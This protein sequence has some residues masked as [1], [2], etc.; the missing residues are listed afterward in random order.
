MRGRR[1]ERDV[2]PIIVTP[3]IHQDKMLGTITAVRRKG[4]KDFTQHDVDLMVAITNQA[5]AAVRTAHLLEQTQ[6][7]LQETQTLYR[8]SR[9][10]FTYKDLP[11]LLR[12]V[13]NGIAEALPASRVMLLNVDREAETVV[14]M[15]VGGDHDEEIPVTFEELW[16]GLTGWVLRHEQ[17]AF[18]AKGKRDARERDYVQEGREHFEFGS[19]IVVPLRY[20]DN[21]FGTITAMNM[22]DEPDFTQRDVDLMTAMANQAAAAIENARL[23][24][25]TRRVLQETR[26]ISSVSQALLQAKRPRHAVRKAT[27][28]VADALKADRVYILTMDLEQR[29]I[30][31]QTKGGPEVRDFW[32]LTFDEAMQGLI[33]WVVREREPVLS[34][35][36][37]LDPR[38]SPA[39][40]H[41]RRD[42]DAGC[43]MI[44]PLEYS[45][46]I[47]GIIAA[48]N[49]S[50]ERD[51]TPHDLKQL[52]LMAHQI[53]AAVENARL[54]EQTQQALA[55]TEALYQV[56][57]SVISLESLR[58]KL[59]I[60]TD[61]VASGLKAN[62]VL[63]ITLDLECNQVV[64]HVTG[65]EGQRFQ[66]VPFE[67]LMAGLTGWVVRERKPA[68]SPKGEPD[69]REGRA[70]QQ[71]RMASQA[72]SILVVPL[73]YEE[74][75]LG[76]LTAI[77]RLDQPD[78]TSDDA[79]LMMTMANQA[80]IAIKN[81]QLVEG[82]EAQV[83]ARTA[84]IRAEQE[85]TEAILQ[86]AGDA[87]AMVDTRLRIRYVNQAFLDLTNYRSEE[88]LDQRATVLLEHTLG[89][90]R[91]LWPSIR[92]DLVLRKIWHGETT[93]S[94]AD[95]STFDAALTIAAV[96]DGSG[97]S[98]G[99]V[100]SHRDITEA[101]RLEKARREFLVNVS[102]QLRTP[103]TTI[104]LYLQLLQQN[105]KADKVSE[106]LRNASQETS[107]LA[108]LIEDMLTVTELDSG[109]ARTVWAEVSLV[110]I[111]QDV[112]TQYLPKIEQKQID[113][114][115][116]L[117][118][119]DVPAVYG[120][121]NQLHRAISELV[122]NAVHFTQERGRITVALNVITEDTQRWVEL[123]VEDNGPGI[124]LGEREHIFERFYRGRLAESGHIPGSGLGLVIA[125]SVVE[126]HGGVLRLLSCD[127]E[128]SKFLI[129]LRA[130]R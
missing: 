35:K 54:F 5:A 119:D 51:F 56:A 86:S 4:E 108:H 24:E 121:P 96:R 72:G 112:I 9:P 104:Q 107:E 74:E 18:S 100:T 45:Q 78:F 62:R 32:P 71:T 95:G 20:R 23:F 67:E 16:D 61:Q 117:P 116:G 58:E 15:V 114:N 126:A 8:A 43:V 113:L 64:H 70:P 118:N 81:A 52:T 123:T 77:N 3:L 28:V 92:R 109:S 102:H 124:T 41:L 103:V 27:D 26:A 127:D 13:V 53:A 101:K 1:V 22:V 7:A 89:Q 66:L 97:R 11:E 39:A 63:L 106:Y 115:L 83:A 105:P 111:A 36:G 2:G 14:D 55:K 46:Q 129:R 90:L 29:R 94:R 125:R 17:P 19:I 98:I 12:S 34:R 21:V 68:I 30:L 6:I 87:I 57:R 60:I 85:K 50:D 65:G 84:E 42:L 99:Y 110:S 33:G 122:E 25:Q 82:L 91:Q 80:A 48:I 93:I 40:R 76:T 31:Y 88:I 130:K 47:L 128:G 120:D 37:A 38:E 44:A 75:I 10:L 69:P 79:D 59:Q 73:M 49:R